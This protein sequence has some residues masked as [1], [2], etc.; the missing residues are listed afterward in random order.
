MFGGYVR[1]QVDL[2]PPD[3]AVPARMALTTVDA[4]VRYAGG[5]NAGP[6]HINCQLREPLA[7]T[8]APWDRRALQVRSHEGGRIPS[9]I[10]NIEPARAFLRRTRDFKPLLAVNGSCSL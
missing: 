7:P 10:N 8:E 6:V 4:A 1:W 2:P 5:P 9:F 3:D